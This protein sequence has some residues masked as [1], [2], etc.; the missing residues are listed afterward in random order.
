MVPSYCSLVALSLIF[1]SPSSASKTSTFTFFQKR[2]A[3]VAISEELGLSPTFAYQF[4]DPLNL[5]TENNF[6]IYREQE[7][8]HGRVAMLA[9][10]GNSPFPN[11]LRH[12]VPHSESLLLSPSHDVYFDD[13]PLGLG[14]INVVP[15]LGW[16]QIIIFIGILETQVFIQREAKAMPGDYGTGYF[17][18]RDKSRH[19]RY[20]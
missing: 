15:I 2:K 18:L 4:F 20:V 1:G 16:I 6:A 10:L 19:E 13:V 3:P 12:L 8:K 11:I 7:L 5:A 17:G 9:V 14:A